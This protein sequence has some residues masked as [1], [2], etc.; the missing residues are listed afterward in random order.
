MPQ[1][2]L[3]EINTSPQSVSYEEVSK[4]FQNLCDVPLHVVISCMNR[5]NLGATAQKT[6]DA[7]G[8]FIS[9]R[10]FPVVPSK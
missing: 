8:S 1:G 10:G 3:N 9:S 6:G 5:S 7:G 4:Y 2:P